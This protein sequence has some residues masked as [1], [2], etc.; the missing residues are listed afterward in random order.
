MQ[1]WQA[2]NTAAIVAKAEA[3]AETITEAVCNF[4]HCVI[5]ERIF[6]NPLDFAV[7]DWARLDGAVLKVVRGEDA[8]RI[9]VSAA[10]FERFDYFPQLAEVRA[11]VLYFAQVGYLAMNPE[12]PME[13]RMSMLDDY[14]FAFTGKVLNAEVGSSF[15]RDWFVFSKINPS[16]GDTDAS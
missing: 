1:H 3:P 10:L 9:A 13:E 6:N 12:E 15:R 5:D 4:F 2:N 14:Y 16:K 7:R 8:N 11:R